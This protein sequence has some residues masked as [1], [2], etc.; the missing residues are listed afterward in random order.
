LENSTPLGGGLLESGFQE[1]KGLFGDAFADS[2]EGKPKRGLA[3]ELEIGT[4]FVRKRVSEGN[5]FFRCWATESHFGGGQAVK[6]S[7]PSFVIPS[8]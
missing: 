1:Q 2:G 5:D 3:G 4:E 8:R 6:V 7:E